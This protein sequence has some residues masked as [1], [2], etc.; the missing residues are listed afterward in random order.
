MSKCCGV[1]RQ[2]VTRIEF[3][4]WTGSDHLG[5]GK[6]AGAAKKPRMAVRRNLGANLSQPAKLRLSTG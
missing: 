1:G 6:F 3:R 5:Y 4:E 2:L